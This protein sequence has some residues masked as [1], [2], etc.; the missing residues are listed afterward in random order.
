MTRSLT[1]NIWTLRRERQTAPIAYD[2]LSQRAGVA[3]L[4]Q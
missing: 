3:F 1:R 4:L 2:T